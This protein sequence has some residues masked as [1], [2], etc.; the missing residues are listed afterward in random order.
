MKHYTVLVLV[1]VGFGANYSYQ[2]EYFFYAENE[3]D[4]RELAIRTAKMDFINAESVEIVRV[5]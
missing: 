2:R 5:N 3:Q 1:S 4:A